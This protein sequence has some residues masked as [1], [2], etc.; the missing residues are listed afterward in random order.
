MSTTLAQDLLNA[1]EADAIIEALA[2]WLSAGECSPPCTGGQI[3]TTGALYDFLET[4]AGGELLRFDNKGHKERAVES[5]GTFLETS[6]AEA[7][8]LAAYLSSRVDAPKATTLD[9]FLE[10]REGMIVVFGAIVEVLHSQWVALPQPRPA[11]PLAALIEAWQVRPVDVERNDRAR[12][13]LPSR[14]AMAGK[15][16]GRV[17]RKLFQPAMHVAPKGNGGQQVL[18]GFGPDVSDLETPCLPLAL[19]D[20]GVG[21]GAEQRG[22]GAPLA[23]RLWIEGVLSVG[24]SDRQNI[25]RPVAIAMT[26]RQLLAALYPSREKPP[27]SRYIPALWAAREA[28]ASNAAMVP[29]EDPETGRRGWR[30]VVTMT[31]VPER[32]DDEIRL[33]VDLPPGV[34]DGPIVSPRLGW[35]GLKRAAHYRALLALAYRWW[36]PGQTRFPVGRGKRRYW[37]QTQDPARYEKVSDAAAVSLC[38]PSSTRGQH[39]KLVHEAWRVL[40]ELVEAGEV[41]EIDGKLLPPTEYP[42]L[43]DTWLKKHRRKR[44]E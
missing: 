34:G 25:D 38:F 12:R 42:T 26:L 14:L 24:L 28:L 9:A 10:T 2:H 22:R 21:R 15:A 19:F 43:P 30:Q 41:H 18:P 31:Q 37:L 1:T 29:W 20:L 4:P 17:G 3:P 16:D 39:R 7:T 27:P 36:S 5:L 32:E 8:V 40:R 35:W 33:V 13:I 44:A 11:H 23:L 6:D